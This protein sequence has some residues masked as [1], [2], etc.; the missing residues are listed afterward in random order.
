MW[1]WVGKPVGPR[2]N[3][4]RCWIVLQVLDG[5]ISFG[6][7]T[8]IAGIL[9]HLPPHEINCLLNLEVVERVLRRH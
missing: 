3:A 4:V 8:A 7:E 6:A 1:P 5:P 2:T 9:G